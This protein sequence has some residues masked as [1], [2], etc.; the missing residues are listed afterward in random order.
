MGNINLKKMKVVAII[1]AL[2]LL[3]IAL[4]YSEADARRDL[5]ANHDLIQ[6]AGEHSPVVIMGK[7]ILFAATR[8]DGH[9]ILAEVMPKF[10]NEGKKILSQLKETKKQLRQLHKQGPNTNL[11]LKNTLLKRHQ[12]LMAQWDV[13]KKM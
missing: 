4:A 6:L 13:F 1:S 5:A 9:K 7:K 2:L 11:A 8:T 10:E 12:K 3:N